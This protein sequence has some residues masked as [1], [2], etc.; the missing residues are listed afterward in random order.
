ML[1]LVVVELLPQSLRAGHR[2]LAALGG[3]VGAGLMALLAVT[4]GV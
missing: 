3:L 1:A 4:L 2:R